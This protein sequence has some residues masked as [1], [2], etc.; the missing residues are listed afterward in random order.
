M[1]LNL[2]KDQEVSALMQEPPADSRV[3][4]RNGPYASV[5]GVTPSMAYNTIGETDSG[6]ISG[7]G[8]HHHST[9]GATAS[10]TI[11]KR[12][13]TEFPHLQT[14]NTSPNRFQ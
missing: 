6:H 3:R 1:S 11:T 13:S 5:V 9:L 8:Q 14:R 7:I 10:F 12:T 4:G 2:V